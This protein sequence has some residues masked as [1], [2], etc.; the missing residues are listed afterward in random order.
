MECERLP[1]H[2]GGLVF[3]PH[4][5]TQNVPQM[6]LGM[7][8]LRAQLHKNTFFDNT[9]ARKRG[10]IMKV[11]VF[12]HGVEYPADELTEIPMKSR[13]I[14]EILQQAENLFSPKQ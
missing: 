6:L 8:G 4:G 2:S 14:E 11:R 10:S 13:R 3:I 5:V 9:Q 12:L 7:A 1:K